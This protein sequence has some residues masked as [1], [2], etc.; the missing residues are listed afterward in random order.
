MP[1]PEEGIDFSQYKQSS[2][3]KGASTRKGNHKQSPAK[4]GIPLTGGVDGDAY[5]ND[6]LRQLEKMRENV[7]AIAARL[8]MLDHP[9]HNGI[10]VERFTL[11]TLPNQP[12]HGDPAALN[13]QDPKERIREYHEIVN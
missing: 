12:R 2:N 13:A 11:L 3:F 10:K 4:R 1:E 5:I 8:G 9:Q 6:R 7:H